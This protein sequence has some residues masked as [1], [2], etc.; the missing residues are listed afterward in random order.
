MY[1]LIK[2]YHPDYTSEETGP[3]GEGEEGNKDKG[4]T[5]TDAKGKVIPKVAKSI[6][7][8]DGSQD[9][10]SGWTAKRIDEMDEDQLGTVPPDIYQK[11]MD[12]ELD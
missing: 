1:S 8:V 9:T 2:E 12:G 5:T 6:A 7:S 11:Y 3:S 10:S 4:K